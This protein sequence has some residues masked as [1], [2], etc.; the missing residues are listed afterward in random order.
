[1]GPPAFFARGLLAQRTL[2]GA[3]RRTAGAQALESRRRDLCRRRIPR[4]PL[5]AAPRQRRPHRDRE[6]I[7]L[8]PGLRRA[9][10]QFKQVITRGDEIQVAIVER[11]DKQKSGIEER[12]AAQR[13]KIDRLDTLTTVISVGR[14]S[15]E[16]LA[17]AE[18]LTD[19]A[20]TPRRR[21]RNTRTPRSGSSARRPSCRSPRRWSPRPSSASS[22]R[23]RSPSGGARWTRRSASPRCAAATRSWSARST[24]SSTSTSAGRLVKTYDVGLGSRS[25]SDKICAG[26]KATP[27]GKYRITKKLAQS[28]YYKALLIN[29]PNDED[30]RQFAQAKRRGAISRRAGIGGLIEI[31]GGGKDGQTYGCVSLDDHHMAETLRPGRRGHAGHDRGR[32]RLREQRDP[33][34]EGALECAMATDSA[35]ERAVSLRHRCLAAPRSA[36]AGRGAHRADRFSRARWVLPWPVSARCS[37]RGTTSPAAP[38]GRRPRSSRIRRRCARRISRSRRRSTSSARRGCS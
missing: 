20:E 37:G 7:R 26:D 10:Q 15:R 6:E 1:M 25:I 36:G 29:Y 38:P 19:E 14:S 3:P 35:A 27:E 5:A 30:R 13:D 12:L 23:S 21:G 17:K 18:L 16:F 8:V 31:H 34:P 33:G 28:R 24:A 22:T 11:R 9:A 4:L 2:R 32:P